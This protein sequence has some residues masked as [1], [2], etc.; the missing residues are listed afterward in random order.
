MGACDNVIFAYSTLKRVRINFRS[1]HFMS[2]L[3]VC[4][5]CSKNIIRSTKSWDFHHPSFASLARSASI[6]CAFCTPL[7]DQVIQRWDRFSAFCGVDGV[8]GLPWLSEHAQTSEQPPTNSVSTTAL[9]RWS[10]RGLGRTQDGK[11]MVAVTF[12]VIPQT[13]VERRELVGEET[14]EKTILRPRETFGLTQQVFYCFP[15]RDLGHLLTKSDLGSSTNPE[16]NDGLQI[17]RW[18][19]TCD[20]EH[21]YCP[22]QLRHLR[23]SSF[24]PT[25][26]LLVGPKGSREPIKVVE[27]KPNNIQAPYLTLSHCW[28]Q[29]P[30]ERRDTLRRDNVIEFTSVGV[31]WEWLSR[32]FQQAI[33]VARFLDMAYIWIDSLCIIQG[34][35]EDWAHEGQLMHKIYRHSNCNLAAAASDDSTGGLFRSREPWQV[36]PTRFISEGVNS[37]FG[38][39]GKAWRVV[40]EDLWKNGLLQTPL[41][42]RAWVFQERILAPRILHFGS[43]QLFW[44]CATMSAC[45]TLPDK[46][47][48]PLDYNAAADRHWRG[49]LQESGGNRLISVSGQNDDSIEDFWKAAVRNYTSCNLTK[50]SDKRIAIWGIAKLVRDS[51]EGGE[52]YAAGMWEHHLEEQLAWTVADWRTSER[53]DS[54][55][56]NPSWSWMSVKSTIL[57]ASRSQE[58]RAYVVKDHEGEP[59]RFSGDRSGTRLSLQKGFVGDFREHIASMTEELE[60]AAEKRKVLSRKTTIQSS[61]SSIAQLPPTQAHTDS[62]F[63]PQLSRHTSVS[64]D[65]SRDNEP[66]LLDNSIA[67]QGYINHGH[68][69]WDKNTQKWTL[70]L[71]YCK[72]TVIEAFP[73]TT[74]YAGDNSATFLILALSH[75]NDRHQSLSSTSEVMEVSSYSGVGILIRPSPLNTKSFVRTGALYIRHMSTLAWQKLRGTPGSDDIASEK[76]FLE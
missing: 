66:T 76:F 28:G 63:L 65:P 64:S 67:I 6:R 69:F 52:E 60:L 36:L 35:A 47:P 41:Y 29:L 37:M 74:L 68:M 44:D 30:G 14:S 7:H 61:D 71:E 55:L 58:R 42:M 24:V 4:S 22:A 15:E 50:Q 18:I 53:P 3:S 9:Y 32:N 70:H 39:S 75:T 54:L 25:R 59:I 21:K 73:D 72:D 56:S 33:E 40:R 48:L 17:K 12:H 5:F 49:R 38:N 43:N 13:C 16:A 26:L 2:H 11:E 51:L 19:S 1:A 10:V 57:L 27:T 46:L 34:D 8:S 20:R 23:R 31:P 45:E 62:N